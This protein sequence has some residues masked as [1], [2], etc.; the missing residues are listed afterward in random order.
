MVSI[1]EG[2]SQ[3]FGDFLAQ[4]PECNLRH[5]RRVALRLAMPRHA[6]RGLDWSG[7]IDA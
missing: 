7:R 2:L 4:M 5:C 1:P 3:E 6:D